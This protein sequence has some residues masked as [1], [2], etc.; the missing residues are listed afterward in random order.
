MSLKGDLASA[1]ASVAK[2]W[3]QEKH[4]A[5]KGKIARH[6]LDRMRYSPPRVT[7]REVAFEV[8][9]AA[10]MKAS[11]DGRYPANKRQIFYAARPAILSRTGE[12]ELDSQYFTQTL[13][14][15]YMEKYNPPWKD[16]VVADAR[17]HIA[18]PH[19]GT[20]VGLGGLEVRQHLA[21]FT[22]DKI[23]ETPDW[24]P[25]RLIE[26]VGPRFRYGAVLFI[27]KEGFGPLLDDAKI[28]ERF[29]VA[30]ASTKGMPVKAACELFMDLKKQ[31]IKTFVVHDFDQSGFGIVATLRTGT[32]GSR[33]TGEIVDLGFRL[34][35]IED[36][37]REDVSYRSD[38]RYNLRRN[39]ASEAEIAILA[40][41]RGSGQRIELNAMTSDQF[42]AWLERKL[43][44]HGIKKLIPDNNALAAAYRRAAF[45]CNF[46]DAAE[47]LRN[48]ATQTI[49]VPGDLATKV[50]EALGDKPEIAWDEAVWSYCRQERV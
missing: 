15:D 34:A 44:E 4:T 26:T 30:I 49:V 10:Y 25:P 39:G 41:S 1:F 21:R 27:E 11:A 20:V 35:D 22:H 46:Q 3:L 8:M 31:G 14:E 12:S 7:I 42:V 37:E 43:V 45:L 2:S 40:S 18:E 47:Q 36:L 5:H 38:P 23:D 6:R 33:G 28:A 48:E 13:L 16:N 32:R 29:D 50:A 17:G 19:T 9:E 24:D